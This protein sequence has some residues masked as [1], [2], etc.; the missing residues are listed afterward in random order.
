MPQ[1][2][3]GLTALSVWTCRLPGEAILQSLFVCL[4]QRINYRS[5]A[6]FLVQDF[7]IGVEMDF[8]QI[9][10]HFNEPPFGTL[11]HFNSGL[12]MTPRLTETGSEDLS[13]PGPDPS[14]HRTEEQRSE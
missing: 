8:Q 10:G 6:N 14:R 7:S 13:N 3:F 9:L 2:V 5:F 4:A 11:F 12:R 1:W